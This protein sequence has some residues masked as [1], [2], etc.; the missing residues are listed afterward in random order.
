MKKAMILFLMAV[1]LTGVVACGQKTVKQNDSLTPTTTAAP[2]Q[3]PEPVRPAGPLTEEEIQF[4]NEKFFVTETEY[5]GRWVR[6]NILF[7]E[8]SLPAQID[9]EAMLYDE[10]GVDEALS[11]DE[12]AYLEEQVG[13]LFDTSKFTK[14]YIN[15][16][17]QTYLGISFEESEKQGLEKFIYY[18]K[19][20]AYYLVRSDALGVFI[21]VETGVRNEDGTITLE[22]LRATQPFSNLTQEELDNLS[23]Y[24]MVLKETENG[25]RFLSNQKMQ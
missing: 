10:H 12:V 2:T 8:F 7:S 18:E 23:K 21:Q 17:L 14:A 22:Y 20:D 1:S 5:P 19:T 13:E 15:E 11:K 9:I 4:F 16:L 6:N 25:Y 3:A 24:Q